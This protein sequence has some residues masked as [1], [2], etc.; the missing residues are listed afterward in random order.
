MATTTLQ[1]SGIQESWGKHA[2]NRGQDVHQLDLATFG[3]HQSRKLEVV[4]LAWAVVLYHQNHCADIRFSWGL[5]N[6]DNHE[7]SSTPEVFDSSAIRLDEKTPVSGALE[8]L[9][10]YV[11][12]TQDGPLI[13]RAATIFLNDEVAPD[14]IFGTSQSNGHSAS[15]VCYICSL[16]TSIRMLLY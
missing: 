6:I 9:Q 13:E 3:K 2:H 16:R 8:R 1:Q 11:Q 12:Q 10:V 15:W 5:Y 14:S 7:L 4:L